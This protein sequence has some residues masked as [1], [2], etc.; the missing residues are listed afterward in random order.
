MSF[1]TEQD[2]VIKNY[3]Q[4]D[5]ILSVLEPSSDNVVFIIQELN[6]AATPSFYV[7]RNSVTQD[8]IMQNGFD[9]TRVDNLTVG[10]ARIWQWMFDNASKV[11]NPTKANVRAGI[12]A[13]WVGTAADLAVRAVV[14]THCYRLA[15][16]LERLFVTGTGST[17]S[18]GDIALH[19][20]IQFTDITRILQW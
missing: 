15:S 20:D 7:W 9:W 19:G 18:P 14:Y 4:A 1:T 8:E 6:K 3:I 12:D 11:I 10:K 13:V 2:L 17:A 5:P 16:I